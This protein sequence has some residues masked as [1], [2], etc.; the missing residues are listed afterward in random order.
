M[1]C[2]TSKCPLQLDWAKA[3]AH[4]GQIVGEAKITV[5]PGT[6]PK[7]GAER[8]QHGSFVPVTGP[9]KA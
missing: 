9:K 6:L 4:Q 3:L 7:P 5:L 2:L 1:T 8:V